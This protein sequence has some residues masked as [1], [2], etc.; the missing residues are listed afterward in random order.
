CSSDLGDDGEERFGPHE[1][2][3]AHGGLALEGYLLGLDAARDVERE[4]DGERARKILLARCAE[5]VE[6]ARL[7][8]LEEA[9]LAPLEIG[10][11]LTSRVRRR[12]VDC[13]EIAIE[14][15]SVLVT[16]P[17]PRERGQRARAGEN[18]CEEERE[19]SLHD[20]ILPHAG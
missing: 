4:D 13:H 9:H 7:P 5:E 16:A 2:D 8:V 3:E 18:D 20:D 11:I 1:I 17:L 6:G 19:G 15:D 14:L 12:Q 10:D